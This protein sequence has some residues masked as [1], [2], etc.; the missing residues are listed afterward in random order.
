MFSIN[1]EET[2]PLA[3]AE[4]LLFNYELFLQTL[5]FLASAYEGSCSVLSIAKRL[6][7]KQCPVSVDTSNHSLLGSSSGAEFF[8]NAFVK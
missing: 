2:V 6:S 4:R 8:N 5:F 3:N 1:I 7:F